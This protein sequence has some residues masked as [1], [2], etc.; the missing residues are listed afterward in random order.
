MKVNRQI[1]TPIAASHELPPYRD[2]AMPVSAGTVGDADTHATY[3]RAIRTQIRLLRGLGLRADRL[4]WSGA[5]VR[6]GVEARR[7]GYAV[8]VTPDGDSCETLRKVVYDA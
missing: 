5:I 8:T 2:E 3:E 4:G 7:G 6:L 1:G